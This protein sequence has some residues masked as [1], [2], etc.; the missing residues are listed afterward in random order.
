MLLTLK[1]FTLG[2]LSLALFKSAKS[3]AEPHD[4]SWV[5]KLNALHESLVQS[6]QKQAKQIMNQTSVQ[7][8]DKS[9][10]PS[11][12]TASLTEN[13]REERYPRILIFVSFSMPVETLRALARD[14]ERVKGKIVFRGLVNNSFKETAAKLKQLGVEAFIDPTLFRTYNVQ[15]VPTFI[16]QEPGT[17]DGKSR[18]DRLSGNVTLNYA[19]EKFAEKGDISG[20]QHMLRKVQKL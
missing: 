15:K 10:K 12:S 11:C 8:S 6:N 18:H 14:A 7:K 4:L 19:L 17:P 16:H 20:A 1:R 9:K 5:H 13:T 3:W 2:V